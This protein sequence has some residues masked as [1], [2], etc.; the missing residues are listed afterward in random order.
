MSTVYIRPC[1]RCVRL[2]VWGYGQVSRLGEMADYRRGRAAKPG[3]RVSLGALGG[4]LCGRD[5]GGRVGGKPCRARHRRGHLLGGSE[6]SR[7]HV[8]PDRGRHNTA[9]APGADWTGPLPRDRY[10]GMKLST[11][12][13][14]LRSVRVN[15]SRGSG[16]EREGANRLRH[17]GSGLDRTG[18]AH[19]Q[20]SCAQLPVVV[21]T[22]IFE[23]LVGSGLPVLLRCSSSSQ[24][25]GVRSLQDR[26]KLD[27]PPRFGTA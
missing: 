13:A 24:E 10:G 3:V 26:E 8:T 19:S 12:S 15:K 22:G 16:L 7:S 1:V 14:H 18:S 25:R 27:N 5:Q 4:D 6:A 9:A 2:A 20:A 17:S 11:V 23:I 21:A